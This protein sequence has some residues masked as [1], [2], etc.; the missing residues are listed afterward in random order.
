MSFKPFTKKYD[1][2]NDPLNKNF[3]DYILVSIADWLYESIRYEK[4]L[5]DRRSVT[6]GG[7]IHLNPKFHRSIS[8]DFRITFPDTWSSFIEFI[9]SDSEI[10]CNVLAYWLQNLTQLQYARMLENILSRSGSAY[11]VIITDKNASEYTVG[12]S[13]IAF[14][15]PEIIEQEAKKSLD[16]EKE[17]EDAWRFCYSRK[18]D[19]DKTVIACQN[20]LE[21]FLRDTYE[22]SNKKPQL[23]KLVG[24]LK[25][26]SK[27]LD[28]KG[29]SALKDK[30]LILD[31]INQVPSL[32]G[33]HT[34]GTGRKPTKDEAE[35]VLH[36]SIYIWNLHQK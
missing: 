20:F 3:P 12:V 5:D 7:A 36:T 13:D 4:L 22:P 10:L 34:S 18:P 32:R 11:K 16:S 19:Y 28:F 31:L 8:I 17:L 23:G 27:K 6:G 25:K 30:S 9:F 24:N 2:K 33:M 35:Y 15:V 1:F 26:A 14:R 29:Q 21:H